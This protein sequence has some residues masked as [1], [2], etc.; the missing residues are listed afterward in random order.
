MII[1][2][3]WKT[4]F[5][6]LCYLASPVCVSSWFTQAL[7]TSTGFVLMTR[8]LSSMISFTTGASSWRSV[9]CP[10]APLLK[11]TTILMT[12]GFPVTMSCTWST[13]DLREPRAKQNGLPL[14]IVLNSVYS[15]WQVRASWGYVFLHWRSKIVWFKRKLSFVRWVLLIWEIEGFKNGFSGQAQVPRRLFSFLGS[16]EGVREGHKDTPTLGF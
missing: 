4:T 1:N 13:F 2:H 9:F 7:Y 15:L 5:S 12:V 3:D 16:Y 8:D 11:L 10:R 14:C 6:W